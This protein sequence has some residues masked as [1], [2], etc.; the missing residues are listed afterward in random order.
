MKSKH[1]RSG[2]A[3]MLVLVFIVL[4]LV[5]LGVA[6]RRTAMALRIETARS[7]QVQRDE[8]S[9]H[10]LARGV[11]LLETGVPPSDPYACAVVINTS[12]GSRMFTVTFMS[13]G[14]DN[15]SVNAVPTG[16]SAIPPDMPS[17]FLP[18]EPEM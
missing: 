12:Q 7:L 3:L 18:P 2:F 13:E 16:D 11:A 8:G 15:W 6:C 4:F 17:V 5:M 10:A 14:G 1:R 9:L